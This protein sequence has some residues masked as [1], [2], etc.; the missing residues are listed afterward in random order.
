MGTTTDNVSLALDA[1]GIHVYFLSA[2]ICLSGKRARPLVKTP[3]APT[4]PGPDGGTLVGLWS[5]PESL[6]DVGDVLFFVGSAV[7]VLL[8]YVTLDAEHQP[9]FSMLSSFLWLLDALLYL[10]S[11]YVMSRTLKRDDAEGG[12]IC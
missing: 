3:A 4:M 2:I 5:S 12:Y 7:D 9:A 1:I 6:E 11:D 8:C 10:R